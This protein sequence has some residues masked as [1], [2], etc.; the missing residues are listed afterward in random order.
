MRYLVNYQGEE[1]F[2]NLDEMIKPKLGYYLE[3]KARTW[4]QNDA[5]E[6]SHLIEGLLEFLGASDLERISQ[7]YLNIVLRQ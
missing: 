3:I 1:F 4:S 5:E 7:D 6:K 2:I